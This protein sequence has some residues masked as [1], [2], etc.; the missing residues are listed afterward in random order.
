MRTGF[1]NIILLACVITRPG[2]SASQDITQPMPVE[3]I[4]NGDNDISVFKWE[5]F[6]KLLKPDNDTTYI[7]NFWATWCR[8]CVEELPEFEAIN[9]E[10]SEEKVKIILVSLDIKNMWSKE[11]TDFVNSRNIESEVIVLYEVD[12]DRWIDEIDQE[13]SGAIPATLFV[14]RGNREFHEGKM[15]KEQIIALLNKVN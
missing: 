2:L 5:E 14:K 13:W 10:F 9:K 4:E 1:L 8:P 15:N 3:I 7:F 6:S 12:A 11:L